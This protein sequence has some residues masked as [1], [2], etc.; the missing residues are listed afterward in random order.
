MK[1]S[2]EKSRPARP[3]TVAAPEIGRFLRTFGRANL[4]FL[5]KP[6][7]KTQTF[8]NNGFRDMSNYLYRRTQGRLLGRFGQLDALLIT[9]QG[10][11]T[12]IDRTTTVAY[13]YDRGRFVVCAVP[14]HFEVPG[15]P[16]AP[17]PGWFV[18][19]RA[20]GRATIDIGPERIPVIS[21]VLAPG[22]ERD[23][24]WQRFVAGYPYIDEMEAGAKRL[25]PLAVLTPEDAAAHL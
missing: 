13:V 1:E 6:P 16:K 24:L 15:G 17:N 25:L 3:E 5:R 19:L 11:K 23:R 4:F 20:M 14:G 22:A 12:G 18:N 7:S 9:T 21:E 2:L 10:R 8:L